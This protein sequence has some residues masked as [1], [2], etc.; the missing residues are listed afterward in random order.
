MELKDLVGERVLD[1]AAIIITNPFNSDGSGIAFFMD[2]MAYLALEDLN[3]GYRSDMGA[4]LTG[5]ATAYSMG[6]ENY[7]LI[8]RPV[9]CRHLQQRGGKGCDIL[10]IIDKETDHVWLRV[11]TENTDDYY[12]YFV[13]TWNPM[14]PAK[15]ARAM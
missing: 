12:P 5:A 14:P 8:N 9:T 11:G 7:E 13:G 10:E 4:I 1:C 15:A 6:A 3:D 2:G